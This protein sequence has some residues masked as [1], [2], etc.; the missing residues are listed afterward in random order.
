LEAINELVVLKTLVRKAHKRVKVDLM[1]KVGD[2]VWSVLTALRGPDEHANEFGGEFLKELTTA[3]VR[4]ILGFNKSTITI[5]NGAL[6]E[7]QVRERNKMLYAGS[8]HF[9]A[10]FEYAL[11]ALDKLGYKVPKLELDFDI[12]P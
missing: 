3:R 12:L 11:R 8:G 7:G 5:N 1:F 9:N 4:A 2:D 10:H 6:T